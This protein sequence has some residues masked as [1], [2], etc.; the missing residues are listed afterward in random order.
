MS[1][2]TYVKYVENELKRINEIIDFK[3]AHGLGYKEET[4]MHK[5]LLT[6]ISSMKPKKRSFSI[7]SFLF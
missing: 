1:K 7:F 3:I 2:N 6:Q 5:S 4:R